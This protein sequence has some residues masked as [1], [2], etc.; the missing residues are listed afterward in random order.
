[1]TQTTITNGNSDDQSTISLSKQIRHRE[2]TITA[3]TDGAEE[4]T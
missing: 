2:T 3:A 4:Q 1:M